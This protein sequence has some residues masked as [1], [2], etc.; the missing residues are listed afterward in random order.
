MH[1]QSIVEGLVAVVGGLAVLTYAWQQTGWDQTFIAGAALGAILVSLS[2]LA[3]ERR[4][5]RETQTERPQR[6]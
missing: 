2:L 1:I 6:Q 3:Y 5:A 4:Q